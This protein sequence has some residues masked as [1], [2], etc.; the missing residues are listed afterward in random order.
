MMVNAM[1]SRK[2]PIT[3][4]QNQGP[5][6]FLTM[7]LNSQEERQHITQIFDNLSPKVAKT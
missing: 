6:R 1:Q 7:G 2:I 4:S 5:E 3:T